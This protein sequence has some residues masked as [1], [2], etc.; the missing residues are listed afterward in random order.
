MNDLKIIKK[1]Y[2]TY[3]KCIHFGKSLMIHLLF[4]LRKCSEEQILER[5]NICRICREFRP[6][7]RIKG[8]GECN[9]CQ[10]NITAEREFLNKL[11]WKSEKCPLDKWRRL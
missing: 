10:C 5:H 8:A 3:R 11:A 7:P 2:N 9:I 4:G 1:V 6:N